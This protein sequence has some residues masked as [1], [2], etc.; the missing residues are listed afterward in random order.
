MDL[1]P[2]NERV[3]RTDPPHGG[4]RCWCGAVD[5]APLRADYGCCRDCGTVVFL[6][7][8]DLADYASGDGA[9]FYG[10]RYWRQH[11][12][13]QLG[14]P[15]LEDRARADLPERAVFHLEKVLDLVE[16]GARLLEL[17]CGSGSL[18]YL[19]RQAGIDA[20]G[21]EMATAAIEVARERFGLEVVQGPLETAEI[22]GEFDAILAVDV[23]EHLPRPLETLA[24]CARRLAAGGVFLAQTPCFRDQGADWQMLLPREHLFLFT[25]ASVESLLHAA[26]FEASEVGDSLFPHDMWIAASVEQLTPR[27]DPLN[28]VS[29]IALALIDARAEI[30]RG[31]GELARVEADRLSKEESRQALGD[32]LASV[33]ADQQAKE[34]L[35]QQQADDSRE[36]R[37][38]QQAKGHL[39]EQLSTQL[40]AVRRDQAAKAELIDRISR[41]LEAVQADRASELQQVRADQAARSEVIERLSAELAEV[42]V[43]QQAKEEV[44]TLLDSELRR[45]QAEL[46][47]IHADRIYRGLRTV[48]SRLGR[49]RP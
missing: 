21:L 19:L 24:L 15:G 45:Q 47:A 44:I 13:E 41:E 23:L 20:V 49:R 33:R 28:G 37:R 35:I 46:D 17:G 42:R 27:P 8:Y 25:A 38:D 4:S 10:D 30:V 11:V 48:Q 34:E 5:F 7:P 9:G 2:Q 1:K 12:P 36:L 29:P 18:T 6:E 14:L 26:G 40:T 31:Q 22:E 16:P 39:I 32:E 43:D 3:G